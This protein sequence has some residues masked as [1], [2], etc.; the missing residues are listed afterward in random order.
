MEIC[1]VICIGHLVVLHDQ[2]VV[3][4]CFCDIYWFCDYKMFSHCSKKTSH[5]ELNHTTPNTKTCVCV[6][7]FQSGR[8]WDL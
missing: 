3:S 6:S 2:Q 4:V 1:T 5:L 8:L 7:I